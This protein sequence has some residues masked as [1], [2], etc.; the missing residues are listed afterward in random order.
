MTEVG[1]GFSYRFAGSG[2]SG[3]VRGRRSVREGAAPGSAVFA[4]DVELVPDSLPA[5]ARP[6][7]LR[8]LRRSLRRDLRRLRKLAEAG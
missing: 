4:Y 3:Q 5:V 1:P 8:W 6:V 7:L 2:D